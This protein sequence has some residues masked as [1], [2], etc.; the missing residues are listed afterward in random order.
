MFSLNLF[1]ERKMHQNLV[2]S[3]ALVEYYLK[4]T[5][6]EK[7]K[8]DLSSAS[9]LSKFMMLYSFVTPYLV[10]H[11]VFVVFNWIRSHGRF[12]LSMYTQRK[13]YIEIFLWYL[14]NK[15]RRISKTL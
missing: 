12:K 14:F 3:T 2:L 6:E 5:S 7:L 10:H 11:V 8:A 13:M 9:C 15:I 1:S 4:F